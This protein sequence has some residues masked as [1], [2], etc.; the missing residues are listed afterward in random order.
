M[1]PKA[2]YLKVPGSLHSL[3]KHLSAMTGDTLNNIIV[4]LIY[5]GLLDY[6][7]EIKNKLNKDSE[8]SEHG[9]NMILLLQEAVKE[10]VEKYIK[11]TQKDIKKG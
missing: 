11:D 2:I 1:Q 10:E 9:E 3:L 4:E 6:T 7:L 8:L 5:K